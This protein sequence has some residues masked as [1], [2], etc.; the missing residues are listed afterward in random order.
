MNVGSVPV[1]IPDFA[2]VA[3][4]AEHAIDLFVFCDMDRIVSV[5][6]MRIFCDCSWIRAP[7][8]LV[9]V[10]RLPPII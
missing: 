9:E 6:G 1:V 2:T 5:E 10:K 3:V 4:D 7:K 8:L